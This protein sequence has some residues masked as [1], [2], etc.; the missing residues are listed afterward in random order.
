MGGPKIWFGG[1]KNDNSDVYVL[2]AKNII[3]II[4]FD[5]QTIFMSFL[6][7]KRFLLSF[8]ALNICIAEF[9]HLLVE[10]KSMCFLI[11]IK[12]FYA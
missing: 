9:T 10:K 5:N 3:S 8:G 1:I 12:Y 7:Y 4:K 6:L 2:K 11:S